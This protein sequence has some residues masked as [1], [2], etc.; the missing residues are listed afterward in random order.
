MTLP[1]IYKS[2]VHGTE[3]VT[4]F[5]SLE[6]F[7]CIAYCVLDWLDALLQIREAKKAAL[8][9][10]K[11][12]PAEDVEE[13]NETEAEESEVAEDDASKIAGVCLQ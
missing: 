1:R 5:S 2:W 11:A 12:K 10:Q 9:E 3:D 4:K 8:L 6:R 13:G 7:W